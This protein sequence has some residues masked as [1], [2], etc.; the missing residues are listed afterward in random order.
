M[1][2]LPSFSEGFP[3]TLLEGMSAGLAV[4]ATRVGAV[5]EVVEHGRTGLLMEPGDTDTLV[6]HLRRLCD[7]PTL[8]AALGAAARRLVTQRYDL[9]VVMRRFAGIWQPG[10]ARPEQHTGHGSFASSRGPAS[11]A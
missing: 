8:R 5:P 6:G 7:D 10:L 3:N 11:A 9:D 4:I 1:L 2:L